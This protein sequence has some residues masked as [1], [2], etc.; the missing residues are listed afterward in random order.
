MSVLTRKRLAVLASAAVV[1]AVSGCAGA[2][3]DAAPAPVPATTT[4]GVTASPPPVVPSVSPVSGLDACA[5]LTSEEVVGILDTQGLAPERTNDEK[6][7][8]VVAES[9]NWGSE[10]EGLVSVGWM[11]EPIPAWGE[12]ERSRAFTEAVG[13]KVTLNPWDGK[14]CT[15]FAERANGNLGINIVPSAEYLTARP[16]SPGDD[17]C[18]RNMTTIVTAFGRARPA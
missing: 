3:H 17:I 6:D 9:C 11:L 16:S 2:D 14:A 12:D 10:S 7:G 5:L 15:V 8:R 4:A 18:D 1:L 13:R